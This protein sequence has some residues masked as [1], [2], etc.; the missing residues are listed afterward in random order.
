MAP[1]K[2]DNEISLNDIRDFMERGFNDLKRQY[3]ELKV[4]Q[5]KLAVQMEDL[6]DSKMS[7][8]KDIDSLNRRVESHDVHVSK[9]LTDRNVVYGGFIVVI[10]SLSV[11]IFA[12]KAFVRQNAADVFE[13]KQLLAQE[14]I[15]SIKREFNLTA[16]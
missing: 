7:H 10:A 2:N 11:L 5:D 8:A 6:R 4:N 9:L 1:K 16:E 3:D 14:L 13:E 15:K 12:G